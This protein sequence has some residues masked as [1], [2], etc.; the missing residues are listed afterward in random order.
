MKCIG[1]RL[2]SS[3]CAFALTANCFGVVTAQDKHDDGKADNVLIGAALIDSVTVAATDPTGGEGSNNSLANGALLGGGS[4]FQYFLQEMSFDNRLVVGAPF[5]ADI[6]SETIQT[7][8]NG[9]LITQRFTGRIYRDSQGR[10]RT[11]RAFQM[12]GISETKHT[13]AIFDPIA[14]VNYTLDP[15]TRIAHKAD[16]SV[17]VIP[18]RPS[19]S[20]T[21][22]S[23][24]ASV[25]AIRGVTPGEALRKVTP[26][27]PMTAR[28]ARVS[29]LTQVLVLISETGDVIEAYAVSGHPLLRGPAVKAARQWKFDPTKQSGRTVKVRGLLNFDFTLIKEEP[30]PDQLA[31]SAAKYT[32]NTEQLRKR[33]VEGVECEGERKVITLAAGAI[34]NDHPIETVSETWYSAEL[35][36][37]ILSKRSDPRFGESTYRITNISRAEP[38]T[39]LFQVPPDYAVK[40]GRK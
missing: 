9:T 5:S 23:L 27:Y 21:H 20:S 35:R 30:T 14:G 22:V 28:A 24:N 25:N 6:F 8:A 1:R 13:I 2:L 29:G 33:I 12:G 11:E 17:K 18:P 19:L 37:I 15:E 40:E 39:A 3:V 26:T 31:N 38:E 10:A 34:G 4:A 32:V 16:S 7:L 36:M